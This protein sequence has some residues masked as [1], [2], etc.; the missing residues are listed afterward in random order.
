VTWRHWTRYDRG[1]V[2]GGEVYHNP[3]YH[4]ETISAAAFFQF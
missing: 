2:L 3:A 1:F 4:R